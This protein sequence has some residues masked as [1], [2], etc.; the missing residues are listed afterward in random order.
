MIYHLEGIKYAKP[1][2]LTENDTLESRALDGLKIDLVEVW[3]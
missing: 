1:E 2:Y 3:A